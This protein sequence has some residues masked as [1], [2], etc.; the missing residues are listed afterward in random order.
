[1]ILWNHYELSLIV[2]RSEID[3][4]EYLD[5]CRY[6]Y[7][8]VDPDK[9]RYRVAFEIKISDDVELIRRGGGELSRKFDPV[10]K[11]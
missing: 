7:L 8:I 1:M 4:I 11:Y 10:Y 9:E 3:D 2:V 5:L 6:K